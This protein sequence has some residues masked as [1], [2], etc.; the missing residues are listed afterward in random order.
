MTDYHLSLS[1]RGALHWSAKE[2]ALHL[3][4]MTRADG[5]PFASV[6]ELR[7][8]LMDQLAEGVEK[9]PMGDCDHFDPKQGCLGHPS[10]E[11][12]ERP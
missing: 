6:H 1:V 9:I 2:A 12:Q 8:A 5:R 7:E 10:A 11:R 3:R 4:G